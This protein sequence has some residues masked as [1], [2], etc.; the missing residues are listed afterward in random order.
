[1]LSAGNKEEVVIFSL[2]IF[3]IVCYTSFEYSAFLEGDCTWNIELP[4]S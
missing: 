4:A 3:I 2:E 1:M